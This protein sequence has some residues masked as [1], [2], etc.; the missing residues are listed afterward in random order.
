MRLSAPVILTNPRSKST[1]KMSTL[2]ASQQA[3][4][5]AKN[6]FRN[7]L[8]DEKLFKDLLAAT[9]VEVVWQEVKKLQAKQESQSR[10]R[11]LGKIQS[12][13][14]KLMAYA[15]T[16]DTFVQVQPDIMALIWGPIRVLLVWT[17]NITKL[18]DAIV[19]AMVKIGDALPQFVE[20]AQIFSDDDR[21]KE[22]LAL[23]YKDI[24]DFFEI[25]LKFF[26][27]SSKSHSR[28]RRLQNDRPLTACRST[29]PFRIHMA[30][31]EGQDWRDRWS[32]RAPHHPAEKSSHTTAH[33][34][35]V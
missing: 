7:S 31:A 16:V 11:R 23:F 15:A 3:F 24:L 9:D 25:A 5:A 26:S 18:A 22:V 6:A 17:D 14:D 33:Q 30:K 19:A 10:L 8:K 28:S 2:G 1:A 35:G 32:Y 27:L 12:F 21:R 34:R 13:L 20:I 4:E 29:G